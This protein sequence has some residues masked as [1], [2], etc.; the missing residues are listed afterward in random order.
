MIVNWG[1][2]IF[3]FILWGFTNTT[4]ETGKFV[5]EQIFLDEKGLEGLLI[6]SG[7]FVYNLVL[8]LFRPIQATQVTTLVVSSTTLL[9]NEKSVLEIEQP[10]WIYFLG[11]FH[12]LIDLCSTF[13]WIF[14]DATILLWSTHFRKLLQVILVQGFQTPSSRFSLEVIYLNSYGLR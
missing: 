7:D 5:W 4:M 2:M 13:C 3:T 10:W 12:T 9:I 8:N 14:A 11:I 1:I 6:Q